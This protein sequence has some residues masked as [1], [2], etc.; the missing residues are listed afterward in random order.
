MASTAPHRLALLLLVAALP[1]AMSSCAGEDFPSGRSY[2]TCEDL[3][4]LGASLHWTYDA[5][6][7]SLSLAFVAAPA[8]PGGWV[9]WGI[10]PAGTGMVGAQALVALAGGTANS[11]V[12]AVVRTYNITGYAPLGVAPTPIAFPATGLAAD[13][14]GGG[15]VR[16]YATLRLDNKGVKKVVNHVWQVGSSVTRGA[17][18]MHAMDPDN[19]ASKGKLV[20]SDG[21]AASA[22]APAGGPSSSGDGSGDGT[23]LSRAIS[24]AADTAGVPAPAVLVLAVLGFLTMTIINSKTQKTLLYSVLE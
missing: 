24:R 21:A 6:G 13:V 14:G 19:L 4:Y 16:L 1:A 7:P 2:V 11:S 5:S 3:P 23:P 17:P 18:D 12:Q 20:L 9:A 8:A 10:N 22:P 15:K